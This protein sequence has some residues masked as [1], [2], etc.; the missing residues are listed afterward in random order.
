MVL[1]ILRH[2]EC[3]LAVTVLAVWVTACIP[4][5]I[6]IGEGGAMDADSAPNGK[7]L[8]LY[9]DEA[10][11]L[12]VGALEEGLQLTSE[13]VTL[14]TDLSR[15]VR[16][17][18]LA[19]DPDGNPHLTYV[20]ER[21]D[22]YFL[23]HG[24]RSGGEWM[25]ETVCEVDTFFAY[26]SFY[27]L[28][29]AIEIDEQGTIHV[30]WTGFEPGG[31]CM[32][33]HYGQKRDGQWNLE[34]LTPVDYC[35]EYYGLG[36]FWTQLDIAVEANG[37]QVVALGIGGLPNSWGDFAS[38]RTSIHVAHRG[39]GEEWHTERIYYEEGYS[40]YGTARNGKEATITCVTFFNGLSLDT[41]PDGGHAVGVVSG[42][43]CSGVWSRSTWLLVVSNR[44]G[45]WDWSYSDYRYCDYG[46]TVCGHVDEPDVVFDALGRLNVAWFSS[47]DSYYPGSSA[48]RI[49]HA[50]REGDEWI[51]GIQWD[52]SV[53]GAWLSSPRLLPS[54][55]T[56]PVILCNG[57]LLD[58][59][60]PNY[61]CLFSQWRDPEPLP[62][63]HIASEAG[64]K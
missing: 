20:Q 54:D 31:L 52:N 8:I 21:E 18:L 62:V 1:P 47:P 43:A 5:P 50:V 60:S 3:P 46:T 33:F 23:M 36:Y 61:I 12:T 35:H 16:G 19:V 29:V 11:E 63:T 41:S 27:V 25:S 7:T 17:R 64:M 56:R 34:P 30:V 24:W 53:F 58:D 49:H 37:T 51:S 38:D 22:A 42:R 13:A 9:V 6:P 28:S 2:A 26:F 59:E 57:R 44:T 55:P 48:P 40:S 4:V 10:D 15:H 45:S 39:S 14:D 32:G